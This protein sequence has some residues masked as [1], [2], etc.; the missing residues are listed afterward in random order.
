VIFR[1]SGLLILVSVIAAG[2]DSAA[3]EPGEALRG[4][5]RAELAPEGPE[6]LLE[7]SGGSGSLEAFVINGEERIAVPELNF[8]AGSLQLKFP[9]YDSEIEAEMGPGELRGRWTKT[10]SGGRREVMDFRAVPAAETGP[11]EDPSDFL[12]TWRV[13][14]ARD[15][16]DARGVFRS[17][18]QGGVV[19]TFETE[20]GDYRYLS[21]AVIDGR[22]RLSCFDGAHAFD[23]RARC[24]E[25][26]GEPRLEGSFRSGKTWRDSWTARRDAGEILSDGFERAHWRGDRKLADLR[27]RDLEGG[28]ASIGRA[29]GQ[30]GPAL[31]YLFGSWCPNC[32]DA[33][34]YLG[35]IAARWA[36]RDLKILGLAFELDDDIERSRR[37]LQRYRQRHEISYPVLWAGL[38]D[39]KKATAAFQGL[40]RVRSYPT[41]LFVDRKGKVRRVYS[42]FAGPATGESHRA[43]KAGFQ[44]ALE[45]ICAP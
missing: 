7:F 19:G 24:R 38:A 5:W 32:Q 11:A 18:G 9:H 17:D 8:S 3:D 30:P 25:E 37:Q 31:V 14:F 33:A 28:Q 29:L 22:L 39:K 12:G 6:F 45:E 43:L 2:C 35:E 41:F 40:D 1:L 21:G 26:E 27:F 42:G 10:K 34:A 16:T 23:F 4:V 15:E 44:A 20:T 36:E 13:R